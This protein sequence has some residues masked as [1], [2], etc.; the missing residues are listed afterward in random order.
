MLNVKFIVTD[1][2]ILVVYETLRTLPWDLVTSDTT[3]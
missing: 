3:Q 1:Q 2:G